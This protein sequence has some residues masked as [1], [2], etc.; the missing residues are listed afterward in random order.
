MSVSLVKASDGTPVTRAERLCKDVLSGF[1]C[2]HTA[3]M[4]EDGTQVGCGPVP[5]RTPWVLRSNNLDAFSDW[6]WVGV[7]P[8]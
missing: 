7:N 4:H 5:L 3:V 6:L 1:G 8:A 2:V